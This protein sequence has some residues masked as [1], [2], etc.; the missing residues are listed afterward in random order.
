MKTIFQRLEKLDHCIRYKAT[1]G[2]V[3]L[4]HKIGI[5]ERTLYDYLRLMREMG[6]PIKFSSHRK[7]YYYLHDGQ[8]LVGFQSVYAPIV[9]NG[10]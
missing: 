10:V 4:A 9:L 3:E 8:F 7:S 1:G 5:S 6:A 2:P